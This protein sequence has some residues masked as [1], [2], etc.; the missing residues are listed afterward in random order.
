MTR[1]YRVYFN[2]KADA[3]NCWSIDEG[4]IDTEIHVAAVHLVDVRLVS[5]LNLA[6][7]N[8]REPKAWFETIGTL[9]LQ[10]NQAFITGSQQ[11]DRTRDLELPETCEPISTR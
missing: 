3:P 4:T 1:P 5:R 11:N 8:I 7:D 9:L 10:E 6:A 2:S